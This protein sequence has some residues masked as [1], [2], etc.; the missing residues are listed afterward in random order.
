MSDV[1]ILHPTEAERTPQ[2]DSSYLRSGSQPAGFAAGRS[3]GFTISR[4]RPGDLTSSGELRVASPTRPIHGGSPPASPP[5]S[6]KLPPKPSPRHRSATNTNAG[7]GNNTFDRPSS[8]LARSPMPVVRSRNRTETVSVDDTLQ[9]AAPYVAPNA[10][11]LASTQSSRGFRG[12][13]QLLRGTAPSSSARHVVP[14]P[15]RGGNRGGGPGRGLPPRGR[16]RGGT[17]TPPANRARPAAASE[18][19]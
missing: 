2:I 19:I 11:M 6:K 18:R 3:A 15:Q 5:P 8:P 10:K 4:S 1:P 16:G 12:R 7:P 14:L 17:A 9:T 13:G